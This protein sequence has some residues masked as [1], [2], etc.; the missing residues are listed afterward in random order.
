MAIPIPKADGEVNTYVL[1]GLTADDPIIYYVNGIQTGGKEHAETAATLAMIAERPVVGVYN[2][3]GGAGTP[4][5]FAI[6]LAQCLGDWASST[7]NKLLEWGNLGVNKVVD[8]VRDGAH[9]AGQFAK[10]PFG[11]GGPKPPPPSQTDPFNAADHVR[12]LVAE[13]KRVKLIEWKLEKYNRATASLFRQ[14]R[15]H[16]GRRQWVV[17]HSQGNLVTCDALWAMV[18]AYGEESLGNMKVYSL[19][20]PSPA[21]PLGIRGGRRKVYGHTNDLVT[22]ADPHNW[23]LILKVFAANVAAGPV[24]AA[25]AA[26]TA[27]AFARTPG[28]WRRHGNGKAPGIAGHDLWLHLDPTAFNFVNR[29]RSDLGLSPLTEKVQLPTE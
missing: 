1:A 15:E 29:L 4:K 21:W 6:D 24:G 8:A 18:L 2:A 10:H 17:A 12:K 23:P 28:D 19:A 9:H 7:G 26:G 16:K 5:G 14:L 22:L 27:K 20:S 11:G 13:D 25:G 3:S